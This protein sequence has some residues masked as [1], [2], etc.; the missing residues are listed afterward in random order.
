MFFNSNHWRGY[1]LLDIGIG[2]M[3]GEAIAFDKLVAQG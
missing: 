2:A 3:A 1:P